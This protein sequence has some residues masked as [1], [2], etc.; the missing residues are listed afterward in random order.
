VS[1]SYSTGSVTGVSN[2][3]GGLMG[4]NGG[5]VANSFY[6]IENVTIN[7]GHHVTLGGYTAGS[8]RTGRAIISL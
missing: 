4:Y 5:S 2:N 3:V 7:G 6:N 8:I 1:N